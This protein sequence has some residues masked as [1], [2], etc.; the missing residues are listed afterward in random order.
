V[1]TLGQARQFLAVIALLGLV[2]LIIALAQV[3]S[4]DDIVR[5]LVNGL[6]PADLARFRQERPT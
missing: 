3:Y 6:E 1:R 5:R 4:A 2:S